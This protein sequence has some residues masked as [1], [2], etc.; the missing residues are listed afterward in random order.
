MSLDYLIKEA[1]HERWRTIVS[2][3]SIDRHLLG[4]CCVG[5]LC[6]CILCKDGY[7]WTSHHLSVFFVMALCQEPFHF[8]L[9]FSLL[10]PHS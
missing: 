3:V 1:A 10:I 7:P 5:Q 2:G 8:G 4:Q 6:A 9:I